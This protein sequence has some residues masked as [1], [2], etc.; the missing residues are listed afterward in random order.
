VLDTSVSRNRPVSSRIRA[1]EGRRVLDLAEGVL[2][3]LR[4]YSP[5]A[6]FGELVAVAHRHDITVSAVA[7]ALVALAT[8]DIEATEPNPIEAAIAQHAWGG[9]LPA[10]PR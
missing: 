7:A 8:G 4:R 9:L 6:A 2:V 3:S 1:P 10:P 5:E